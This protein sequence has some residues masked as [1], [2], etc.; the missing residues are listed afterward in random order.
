[1]SK[2]MQTDS[3]KN[4]IAEFKKEEYEMIMNEVL[5]DAEKGVILIY[6][7]VFG[8]KMKYEKDYIE[9]LSDKYKISFDKIDDY[10]NLYIY[11]AFDVLKKTN[12]F[13]KDIEVLVFKEKREELMKQIID[14]TILLLGKYPYILEVYT[15]QS[16][17]K[18]YFIDEIEYNI[19]QIFDSSI[20]EFKEN[21]KFFYATIKLVLQN[22]TTIQEDKS[23][24]VTIDLCK[25]DINKLIYNLEKIKE[26]LKKYP[27]ILEV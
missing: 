22:I 18:T 15:L 17:S 16:L 19:N 20:L 8:V 10:I 23:F 7:S 6:I 13:I 14:S 4:T 2:K 25:S 5:N 27:S 12:T 26:K 3:F 9:K 21:E 1:M 11:C 24:S